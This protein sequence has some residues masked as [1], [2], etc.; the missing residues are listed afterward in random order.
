MFLP[1]VA[2]KNEDVIFIAGLAGDISFG[3]LLEK[4]AV[5]SRAALLFRRERTASFSCVTKSSRIQLASSALNAEKSAMAA[6]IGVV[7]F[8]AFRVS[9]PNL[10]AG[11]YSCPGNRTSIHSVGCLPRARELFCKPRSEI[12]TLKTICLLPAAVERSEEHTS[13]LQSHS[14]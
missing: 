1:G 5:F 4:C 6:S 3:P 14:F 9:G 2:D 10:F 7:Q 11:S 13:E 8:A 12:F